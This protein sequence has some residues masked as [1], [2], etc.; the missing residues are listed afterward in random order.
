MILIVKSAI[1][2]E[3]NFMLNI[4]RT[5]NYFTHQRALQKLFLPSIRQSTQ[6]II[7]ILSINNSLNKS[8]QYYCSPFYTFSSSMLSI[9]S[10]I[11][12]T[13]CLPFPQSS[14]TIQLTLKR[15]YS[16]IERYMLLITK[17]ATDKMLANYDLRLDKHINHNVPIS[18]HHSHH[19]VH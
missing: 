7:H 15:V 12:H 3:L 9:H 13:H 11:E 1:Q 8:P 5:E 18:L 4:Y 16:H 6:E 14:N 19:S 17:S 10:S 2:T